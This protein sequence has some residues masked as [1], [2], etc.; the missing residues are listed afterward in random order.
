MTKMWVYPFYFFIPIKYQFYQVSLVKSYSTESKLTKQDK[1]K[2]G[3]SEFDYCK[4]G[5]YYMYNKDM[6]NSFKWA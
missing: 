5:I 3:A 4:V 6:Y 1:L 2:K